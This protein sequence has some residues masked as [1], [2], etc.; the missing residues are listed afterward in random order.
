[1]A[2]VEIQL[3]DKGYIKNALIGYYEFDLTYIYQQEH[4]SLMHKWVIMSNP[5]GEDFGEVTGYLKISMTVTGA[6]DEQLPIEDDPNP[7]VEEMISP[8]TIKPEFYQLNVRFFCAQN[9]VALDT[10]LT[11]EDSSDVYVRFDYKSTKLKTKVLTQKKGGEIHWNQEFFV[12]VQLP[13]IG[14]NLNFTIFDE[15]TAKR[16]EIVGSFSLSSKRIID[17]INGKYFWKNL[18]GS[19]LDCSGKH[20]DRMNENP[21]IA[22]LW[23]GR[24]LM[25]VSAEKTDTPVLKV[26]N[27][28]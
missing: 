11:G 5:E 21:L 28:E 18:Y 27:I 23:K 10:H 12:P 6:G 2:K 22:S 19:P 7:D 9:I 25:Q 13:I 17:V 16:D 4:H 8:P 20:T 24:I 1:M 26:C 3:L 15:N 14:G